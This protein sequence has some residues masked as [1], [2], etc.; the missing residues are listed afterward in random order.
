MADPP[1]PKRTVGS[2]VPR[3]DGPAKVTGEARYVDD[4]PRRPGE[5]FGATVRSSTPRGKIYGI[6]F[7]EGFDWSDV[8]V[9]RASDIANNIVA[10]IERDQ[11]IL[12]DDLVNHCYEP[13]VL[14]A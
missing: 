6:R 10:L 3:V 5:L 8:I 13:I 2:N 7:D 11:P 12:A 14:L 4:L 1:A 9:V